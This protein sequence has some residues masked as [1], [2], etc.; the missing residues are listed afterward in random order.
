MMEWLQGQALLGTE[1][2]VCRALDMFAGSCGAAGGRRITLFLWQPWVSPLPVLSEVTVTCS[3]FC[4]WPRVTW[5]S[6]TVVTKCCN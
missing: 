6:V 3:L 2:G 4:M 1:G 5:R